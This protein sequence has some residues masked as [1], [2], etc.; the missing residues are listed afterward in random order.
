MPRTNL[1]ITPADSVRR[2]RLL[3]E[4]EDEAVIEDQTQ[5]ENMEESTKTTDTESEQSSDKL[6]AQNAAI[7]SLSSDALVASPNGDFPL[8]DEWQNGANTAMRLD[9]SLLLSFTDPGYLP[10]DGNE[11]GR[12]QS[13]IS[14]NLTY[15]ANVPQQQT[16]V[17][18]GINLDPFSS[19]M[20]GREFPDWMG[21]PFFAMANS[22]QVYMPLLS[23][24]QA[25]QIG[26]M[27]VGMNGNTVTDDVAGLGSNSSHLAQDARENEQSH[28][29][30]TFHTETIDKQSTVQ[31]VLVQSTQD[32]VMISNAPIV[33]STNQSPNVITPTMPSHKSSEGKSTPKHS[34][35]GRAI[36]PSTRLEKMNEIGSN[37]EPA[38]ATSAKPNNEWVECAK[39]YMI[40]LKLGEDWKACIDGW[41]MVEEPLSSKVRYIRWMHPLLF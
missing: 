5:N 39:Q 26:F 27:P 32:N 1:M 41:L 7:A 40:S 23:T 25:G 9:A 21:D 16:E 10:A 2:S 4:I 37:K 11:S 3:A 19:V 30:N 33:S 36:V 18:M 12:S 14:Q 29:T 20:T 15:G 6:A 34:K 22:S 38:A 28:V 35:S 24:G 31:S 17:D 13:V 8:H